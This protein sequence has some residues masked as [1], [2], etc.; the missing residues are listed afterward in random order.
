MITITNPEITVP[1]WL[2]ATALL[3]ILD[4]DTVRAIKR[5][6]AIAAVLLTA[7]SICSLVLSI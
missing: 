1:L 6:L 3:V 5:S 7:H 4:H 2:A